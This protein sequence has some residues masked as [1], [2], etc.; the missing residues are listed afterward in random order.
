ML[1]LS[2]KAGNEFITT[3]TDGTVKWWDYRNINEVVDQ[4]V[5]RETQAE[6]NG[7]IIGSNCFEYVADYGPKY[8]IGT[9]MGSI[10]LATKKPKKSVEINYNNSYGLEKAGRHLGP[11]TSIK[12]N[13]LF[14]RFFMSIGDW[15]VN[16]R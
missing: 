10:M 15:Q 16:V 1:W 5:V 2:S 3:S 13:P 11:V 8:L 4:L 12:R 6:S 14:P 7:L 9:E